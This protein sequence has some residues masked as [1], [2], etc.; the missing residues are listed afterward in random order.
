[1]VVLTEKKLHHALLL[2]A[3]RRREELALRRA[4]AAFVHLTCA[5]RRFL[6]KELRKCRW[7]AVS[8]AEGRAN[9][10]FDTAQLFVCFRCWAYAPRIP[11]APP[12]AEPPPPAPRIEPPPG[13]ALSL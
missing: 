6:A 12:P 5:T 9:S 10:Y 1:M 8:Y 13:L 4:F 2:C 7:K 11:R 3:R